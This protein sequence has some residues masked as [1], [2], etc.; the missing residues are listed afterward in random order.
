MLF[1][2]KSP[3]SNKSAIST[4]QEGLISRTRILAK[5]SHRSTTSSLNTLRKKV[6]FSRSLSVMKRSA[7][8]S[9]RPT[10]A[11]MPVCRIR[12]NTWIINSLVEQQHCLRLQRQ[13]KTSQIGK[14]FVELKTHSRRSRHAI[15]TL[16]K[17]FRIASIFHNSSI[18]IVGC[19]RQHGVTLKPQ[20]LFSHHILR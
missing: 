5:R 11:G 20:F 12:S 15:E 6:P 9:F 19:F 8:S 4:S 18:L 17:S 10:G 2:L 7:S 3:M 13:P 16:L 14:I 1:E